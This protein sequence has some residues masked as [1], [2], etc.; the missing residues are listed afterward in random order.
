MHETTTHV[1]TV[2]PPAERPTRRPLRIVAAPER[3]QY[4]SRER[5]TSW[6]LHRAN[7]AAMQTMRG[8]GPSAA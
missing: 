6:H 7:A 4:W 8:S 3:P 1:R 2:Q 5:R